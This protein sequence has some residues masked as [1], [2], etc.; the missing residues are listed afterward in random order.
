MMIAA[1]TLTGL[2]AQGAGFPAVAI[3]GD[4]ATLTY[5]TAEDYAARVS[6]DVEALRS[7]PATLRGSVIAE[8]WTDHATPLAI[9]LRYV[10]APV[11]APRPPAPAPVPATPHR[12]R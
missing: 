1:E 10:A 2:L 3:N 4:V 7:I 11:E 12:R 9:S 6:D 5:A 8:S